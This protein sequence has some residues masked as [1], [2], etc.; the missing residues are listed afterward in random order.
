[1][2]WTDFERVTEW[3]QKF[4]RAV[5][6]N[7]NPLPRDILTRLS[8]IYSDEE[9]KGRRWAWRSLYYFHRMEARYKRDN[10]RDFLKN[11]R[12]ELNEADAPF[13]LKKFIR[14]VTR[15]VALQTRK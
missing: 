6:T 13:E 12:T 8:Q 5:D 15:W 1:M 9:L 11:L 4:L 14:V 7:D 3:H 10:Q 2:A